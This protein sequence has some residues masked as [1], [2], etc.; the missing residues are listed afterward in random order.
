M[1]SIAWSVPLVLLA[2]IAAVSL[3]LALVL[4]VRIVRQYRS[5]SV[6]Y[7]GM[8]AGRPRMQW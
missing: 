4:L 8:R 3:A 2:V 5:R 1:Y 7:R 6:F